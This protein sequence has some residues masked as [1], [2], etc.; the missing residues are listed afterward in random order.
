MTKLSLTNLRHLRAFKVNNDAPTQ[1]HSG[2]QYA[3]TPKLIAMGLLETCT[4]TIKLQTCRLT[5]AGMAA[6]KNE[7]RS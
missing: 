3:D 1:T 7:V 4:V 5:P 2:H 6:L